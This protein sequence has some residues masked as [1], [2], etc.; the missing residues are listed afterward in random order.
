M[1]RL[2]KVAAEILLVATLAGDTAHVAVVAAEQHMAAGSP[3]RGN[4]AVGGD[5]RVVLANEQVDRI[6][7]GAARG[8]VELASALLG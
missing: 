2:E 1:Q 6:L 4:R 3:G 8:L 5:R 7:V